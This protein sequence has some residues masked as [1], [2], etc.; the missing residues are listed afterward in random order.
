MEIQS[1]IGQVVQPPHAVPQGSADN[2]S[3]HGPPNVQ[4]TREKLAV[5]ASVAEVRPRRKPSYARTGVSSLQQT[6]EVLRK[7]TKFVGPGI[8]ISVAYIDPDNFQTDVSSG[9]LFRFKLLFMILI[10]NIIAIFLQTLSA[11]LGSVTGMDLAQMNRTFLPRWMN[12]VLWVMAEAAIICTDIGQVIGTAIALNLLVPKIPLMAGCALSIVDTLFIL[13]FYRPEGSMRGLR[14]FEVFIAAIV[15]G[16]IICFCIQLSMIEDTAVSEVFRGYLPSAEIFRYEGL[17]ESCAILGG[18]IM[19]HA[20]YLGSS[21]VQARLR[22]FD[23]KNDHFHEYPSSDGGSS[24]PLYRPS[25]SAIRSCMSYS[26]AE[27]CIT[28]FIISIFVNS[29]ILIVAAVSLSE[30]AAEADLFGMYALFSTSISPAA[31]TLF[32][33]GLLFSGTSAGIV[34]TMAGQM[35]CEGAMNW[36]LSPFLRRL[37]TRS[38]SIV[39]SIIVAAAAGRRGLSAALNGANVALSVVLIFVTAPLI[40]YTSRDKYMIVRTSDSVAHGDDETLERDPGFERQDAANEPGTLS[41]A[42]N[43]VTTGFGVLIWAVITFMNIAT[44]V[45]MGLGKV[46]D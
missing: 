32:A 1:H 27:L 14:A 13:F 31:A 25:L 43:W 5:T 6:G 11:K 26:I 24:I 38:I 35:I 22:D 39:P 46:D 45:L 9:A 23:V 15:L 42:N 20:L 34:A 28:L 8:L 10:S 33:L 19:P 7:F 41:L 44:W 12:I 21:I 4:L 16:V 2:V 30:G 37:V 18:T 40:L 3:P 17:Y 29:A 36:R